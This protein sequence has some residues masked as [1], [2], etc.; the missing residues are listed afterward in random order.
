MRAE[1]LWFLCGNFHISVTMTTWVGSTQIS[2]TQLNRPFPK[3]PIWRKNL[4][5][6]SYTSWAIADFLMK[7]T[8]FCYHG[9]KGWSS[10]NLNDSIGLVD[11]E[12][13]TKMQNTGISLKCELSYCDFCVEISTFSL[14]W[15]HGLVRHKFHLLK[16]AVPE[17]TYL[18]QESW[19]YLIHKL[20]YSRLS[21]EICRFLLPWQQRLV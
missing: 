12:N 11:P 15:Q 18:A 3:T 6:I 17:N 20:S 16:S 13:P 1:L 8:D 2:L 5:D 21:D 9:N 4:D 10:E 7:F 19:R 14:P